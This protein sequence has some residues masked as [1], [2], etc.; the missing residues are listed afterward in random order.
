MET[1]LAIITTVLVITQIIRLIQN[2]IQLCK[3]DILFK[4]QLKDLADME[5]TERDFETQRKAYRLVVE[6]FERR[7]EDGK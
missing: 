7:A 1:Y 5:L 2:T 6:F 3:Q 4:K